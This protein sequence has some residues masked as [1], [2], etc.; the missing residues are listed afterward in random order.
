M[1]GSGDFAFSFSGLKTAVRY[2]LPKL[3]L[4]PQTL[5]DVCASFQRAVV[6]VLVAKTL[7]ATQQSSRETVAVSGGVSLNSGLRDAFTRACAARGLE[8]LLAPPAW[9]T[10]NAAMIAAAAGMALEAGAATSVREDIDPNLALR[11]EAMS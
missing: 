5:A 9:C 11:Y 2:L 1:L 10:D 7:V 4:D 8:L 3:S 6:D